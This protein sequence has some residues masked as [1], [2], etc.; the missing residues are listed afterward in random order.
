MSSRKVSPTSDY[1]ER[2]KTNRQPS[3]CQPAHE[4]IVKNHETNVCQVEVEA[5]F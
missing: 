3:L 2:L 4:Q 5:T 1:R